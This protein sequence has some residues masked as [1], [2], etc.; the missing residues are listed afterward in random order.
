MS[1]FGP[2]YGSTLGSLGIILPTLDPKVFCLPIQFNSVSI[3]YLTSLGVSHIWNPKLRIYYH[4]LV[5]S[6]GSFLGYKFSF[7]LNFTY[8][9]YC[10]WFLVSLS[11]FCGLL[12][13][14]CML[15]ALSSWYTTSLIWTQWNLS[16]RIEFV[17][18]PH[19]EPIG[20][21]HSYTCLSILLAMI[22]KCLSL[23]LLIYKDQTTIAHSVCIMIWCGFVNAM[24]YPTSTRITT[25]M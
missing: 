11:S 6:L 16:Q 21:L 13:D 3:F 8:D 23:S 22:G 25:M 14:A 1:A 12:E 5:W 18:L 2:S 4:P 17:F 15:T 10:N 20:S 9:L 7:L 24:Y 19:V